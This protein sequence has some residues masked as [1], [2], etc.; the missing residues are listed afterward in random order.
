MRRV[1]VALLILAVL[2]SGM[3]VGVA[4][5][6]TGGGYD[7]HWDVLGG[8]GYDPMSGSGYTLTGTL[9]QTAIG[10][11]SGGGFQARHGFW[12]PLAVAR[13]YLP[14]TIK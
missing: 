10:V 3:A 6:Q 9:G 2:A 12:Y 11:S 4:G 7:L 8:G 1:Y 5:A 14:L 13:L